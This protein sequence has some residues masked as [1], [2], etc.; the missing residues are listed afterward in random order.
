MFTFACTQLSTIIT[1]EKNLTKFSTFWVNKMTDPNS[2]SFY[3]QFKEKKT[4][5]KNFVLIVN[6]LRHFVKLS[7][8]ITTKTK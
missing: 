5:D 8:I 2:N 1:G 6:I 4:A 7:I 3:K